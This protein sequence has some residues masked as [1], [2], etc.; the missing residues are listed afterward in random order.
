MLRLSKT[1]GRVRPLTGL[2]SEESKKNND[3]HRY[4]R[5]SGAGQCVAEP[6]LC[7]RRSGGS[8]V[9]MVVVV[10]VVTT[11][12]SVQIK[13]YV[14][15]TSRMMLYGRR[16]LEHD[17]RRS[18]D[19]SRSSGCEAPSERPITAPSAGKSVKTML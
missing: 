2:V 17:C 6:A 11:K 16:S 13:W 3:R 12:Y 8:K 19:V 14:S 15:V 5:G 7:V 18:V 9:V 4:C 10:V 1:G